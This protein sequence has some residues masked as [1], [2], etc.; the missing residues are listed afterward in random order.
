MM[1][2]RAMFVERKR[3][4]ELYFD[5]LIDII[6]RDASL[7]FPLLRSAGSDHARVEQAVSKDLS[8]TLKA[9]GFLLLYNLVEACMTAGFDD[10]HTQIEGERGVGADD[11][12]DRL[13]HR[14]MR[15]FRS[16]VLEDASYFKNPTSASILRYWLDDHK[17]LLSQEKSPLFSG[18]L[19]ARK[20]RE[21]GAEYGFS[22][23]AGVESGRHLVDVKDKRN[24]LAHGTLG[25]RE[26]GRDV[27]LDALLTIR[28]DVLQHMDGVI[29]NIEIYLSTRAYLRVA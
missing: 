26:C 8:H 24:R 1:Q 19:D 4:I 15:R 25:F 18:N 2:C 13:A 23:D 10:I 3:E 5:L 28:S 22:T 27:S 17:K 20:I 16:G 12:V 7:I 29:G 11:L 9:N 21:I 6:D 14:A